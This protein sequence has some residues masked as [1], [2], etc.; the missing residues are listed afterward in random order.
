M[1]RAIKLH[2]PAFLCLPGP[3]LLRRIHVAHEHVNRVARQGA[4]VFVLDCH[5]H[6][7]QSV[8]HLLLC[9]RLRH[10]AFGEG[11][12]ARGGHSTLQFQDAAWHTCSQRQVK[13]ARDDELMHL[14]QVLL[15]VLRHFS[16]RQRTLTQGARQLASDVRR[17]NGQEACRPQGHEDVLMV[18]LPCH[19]TELSL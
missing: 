18:E 17:P 16:E 19:R 14:R 4:D 2:R 1:M 12:P 9:P 7:A 15:F 13:T 3:P 11:G 8:A 5:A 10:I 6:A